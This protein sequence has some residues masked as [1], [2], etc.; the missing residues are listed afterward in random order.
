MR[1]L[2]CEAVAVSHVATGVFVHLLRRHKFCRHD[3]QL[4][5]GVPLRVWRAEPR[6]GFCGDLG[7]RCGV[8]YL[9]ACQLFDRFLVAAQCE[10]P[11]VAFAAS[12]PAVP[13]FF[14]GDGRACDDL[15]FD[16]AVGRRLRCLP[17]RVADNYLC[18][19]GGV[20]IFGAE[21][22]HIS[23]SVEIDLYIRKER[24]IFAT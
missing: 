13:V 6:F 20:F 1:L 24:I 3:F 18:L 11:T 21:I 15:L 4:L 12:D 14:D 2:L 17:Y 8:G 16:E 22:F 7:A 23:G 5:A 9:V 10:F 19:H